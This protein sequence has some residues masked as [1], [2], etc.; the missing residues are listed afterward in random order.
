M[1]LPMR[2]HF[3]VDLVDQATSHIAF[4]KAVNSNKELRDPEV[5]KRALYRYE[6]F[7]LPLAA[8]HPRE[9]LSAPMD[10]E[11]V[12]HCH[13]L[14]P[15]TYEKDCYNIVRVTVN[16]TI[17]RPD[18]FQR[19]RNRAHAYWSD[20]YSEP[21]YIDYSATFD[22]ETV[23]GFTS[24]ISYDI[25]SA[26]ER[27]RSFLYQVSLPHYLDR[28]FL[29]S[30]FLRY[31]QFLLLKRQY[32]NEFLVPCYDIDLMWHTHQLNP[33]IYKN[34]TMRIVGQL[35]NHDDSVNERHEGSKLNTADK[36]TRE[37]WKQVYN[38]SFSKFGAMFRG[39]PPDGN[40]YTITQKD[41]FSF[42]T[43]SC[44]ISLD[45]LTLQIPSPDLSRS[46]HIELKASSAK[47]SR[48]EVAKWFKLKRPANSKP[49]NPTISWS[50][51]GSF[52][53]STKSEHGILFSIHQKTG[54]LGT[55]TEVDSNFLDIIPIVESPVNATKPGG[56]LK[57][58]LTFKGNTT[59]DVQ[60]H[61]QQPSIGD[62]FLFLEEGA[63]EDGQISDDIRMTLG[64]L[65]NKR[66]HSETENS[67]KVAVHK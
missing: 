57:R 53:F 10:I 65:G 22:M 35:F 9:Y 63:Y 62:V 29:E 5:L 61:F 11:W 18:E 47:V 7:W 16:H 49:G 13:M 64:P 2:I 17:L 21:F 66:V 1:A 58:R 34:D 19:S 15:K 12:W 59:L 30:G 20:K 45:S 36:R 3:G 14:S 23:S 51:V 39:N 8:E 54:L 6:K 43:K 41:E 28:K 60:G 50:K 40:F 48:Q 26:V 55:K 56:I 4:L 38:E 44:V 25:L 31:K 37:L 67:C 27:Q 32:P 52:N 24:Q 46:K 42:C 33:I